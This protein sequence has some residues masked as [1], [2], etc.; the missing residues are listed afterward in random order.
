MIKFSQFLASQNRENHHFY[1]VITSLIEKYRQSLFATK[2]IFDSRLRS[3][4]ITINTMQRQRHDLK[5]YSATNCIAESAVSG[6]KHQMFIHKKLNFNDINQLTLFFKN[7][8]FDRLN[9]NEFI[10]NTENEIFRNGP[11][12]NKQC[13][14][15]RENAQNEKINAFR[16][17]EK[18]SN[19]IGDKL[20]EKEDNKKK[21]R[22]KVKDVK[23]FNNYTEFKSIYDTISE[24]KKKSK[25]LKQILYKLQLNQFVGRYYVKNRENKKKDDL[26]LMIEQI[27][28]ICVDKGL[29]PEIMEIDQENNNNHNH[30][31]H[32]PQN[33]QI[34][35][36]SESQNLSRNRHGFFR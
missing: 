14:E 12:L 31:H 20:Q 25:F 23:W 11:S 30:N 6:V 7:N 2:S 16:E 18:S 5:R 36:V 21:K 19:Q 33:H 34:I 13:A 1:Q 9:D 3:K 29:W 35:Q 28:K 4:S 15:Y 24:F 8:A 17:S 10:Q 32:Q 27:K 26:N 22:E